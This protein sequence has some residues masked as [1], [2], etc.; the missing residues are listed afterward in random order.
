MMV[1]Y[2]N[3]QMLAAMSTTF[4]TNLFSFQD[5][6]FC[7]YGLATR[8]R[9]EPA[10]AALVLVSLAGVLSICTLKVLQG[11]REKRKNVA[12]PRPHGMRSWARTWPNAVK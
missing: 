12:V 3:S 5:S 2:S 10:A 8:R 6:K 1:R 11:V 7:S 9:R 4:F